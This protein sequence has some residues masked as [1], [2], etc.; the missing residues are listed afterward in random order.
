MYYYIFVRKITSSYMTM[1]GWSWQID[2]VPHPLCLLSDN[3]VT[4]NCAMH[5]VTWKLPCT[6]ATVTINLLDIDSIHRN[7]P[8]PSCKNIYIAICLLFKEAVWFYLT[9]SCLCQFT[10]Y[11][12][13]GVDIKSLIPCSNIFHWANLSY[14]VRYHAKYIH[15]LTNISTVMSVMRSVF[16]LDSVPSTHQKQNTSFT[17]TSS[18]V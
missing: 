13:I 17:I 14:H 8:G 12:L 4:I 18:E 3:I 16:P 1:K 11:P 9:S 5:H 6:P 7:I 15:Q 10:Y 2:T